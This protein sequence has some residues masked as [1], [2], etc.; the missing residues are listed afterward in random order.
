M[1]FLRDEKIFFDGIFFKVHLKI[2]EIRFLRFS[3]RCGGSE[4]SYELSET[5][6]YTKITIFGRN[7]VWVPFEKHSEIVMQKSSS[8]KNVTK[9][10]LF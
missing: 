2:E 3:D 8:E 9:K 4:K 1:I 10:K 6:K 7:R 5:R